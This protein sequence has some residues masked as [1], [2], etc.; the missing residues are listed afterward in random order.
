MICEVTM[1]TFIR[2][3]FLIHANKN[4]DIT[5]KINKKVLAK[6]IAPFY[7]HSKQCFCSTPKGLSKLKFSVSVSNISKEVT[8]STSTQLE[9]ALYEIATEFVLASV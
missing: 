7:I 9:G 4:R 1:S 2:H 8:S 6:D 5:K 3:M